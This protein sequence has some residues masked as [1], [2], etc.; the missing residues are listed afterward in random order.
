MGSDMVNHYSRHIRNLACK[1]TEKPRKRNRKMAFIALDTA[2]GVSYYQISEN[3]PNGGRIEE[4]QH[5]PD[6]YV[7][8]CD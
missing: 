6:H 4:N 7:S 3:Q 1:Y 5:S 2:M 8:A